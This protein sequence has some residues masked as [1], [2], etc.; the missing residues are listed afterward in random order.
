M[1]KVETQVAGALLLTKEF[2]GAVSTA[3]ILDALAVHGLELTRITDS[4]P[5]SEAYFALLAEVS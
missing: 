2:E 4:N 5:A 1:N 3:D